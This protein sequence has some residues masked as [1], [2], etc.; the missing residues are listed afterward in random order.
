ML[1]EENANSKKT[2]IVIT[3]DVGK[4]SYA[5]KVA[6][7]NSGTIVE[8]GT[9]KELLDNNGHLKALYNSQQNTD[10]G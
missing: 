2:I 5:T 3:H 6:V 10:N 1:K 7:V 4:I 9:P 8:F